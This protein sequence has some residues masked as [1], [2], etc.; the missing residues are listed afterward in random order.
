[1]GAVCHD[2]LA[3]FLKSK[4]SLSLGNVVSN[5]TV[6][7]FLERCPMFLRITVSFFLIDRIH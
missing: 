7:A 1:M 4:I 3:W 5:E 6:G 2:L